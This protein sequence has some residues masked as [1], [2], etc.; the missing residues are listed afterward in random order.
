MNGARVRS[1]GGRIDRSLA[2]LGLAVGDVVVIVAVFSYGLLAHNVDPTASVRYT[3]LTILP[4]LVGWGLVAP[5]AGAYSTRARTSLSD[6]AVIV[7]AAWIGATL[8]GAVIRASPAFHG[9]ADVVFVGVT[10]GVGLL[11]LLP[12]RIVA[13]YVATRAR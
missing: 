7:A 8:V 10:I 4:F 1:V 12:W 2:T 11:A 9:G 5:L 3:T 6:T 13:A